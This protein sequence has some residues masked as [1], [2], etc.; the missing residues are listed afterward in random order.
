MIHF[1]KEETKQSRPVHKA[2]LWL[3]LCLLS[4]YGILRFLYVTQ[5]I[6]LR[7]LGG[8]AEDI[9]HLLHFFGVLCLLIGSGLL[10]PFGK[11]GNVKSCGRRTA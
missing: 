10:I 4:V 11:R 9:N 1:S 7:I 6:S 3:A 2:L 8:T 5:E